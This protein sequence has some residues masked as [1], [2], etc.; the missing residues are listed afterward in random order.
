VIYTAL[1][2]A[3][4]VRWASAVRA[5]AP[6]LGVLFPGL[7]VGVVTRSS[8]ARAVNAAEVSDASS[9]SDIDD[10]DF[11][12]D[13]GHQ[14]FF[15]AVGL[16]FEFEECN[17]MSITD[18]VRRPGEA[19]DVDN[20]EGLAGCMRDSYNQLTLAANRML[21]I[22]SG[23]GERRRGLLAQAHEQLPAIMALDSCS[24]VGAEPAPKRS[25]SGVVPKARQGRLTRCL[26]VVRKVREVVMRAAEAI[27]D[28]RDQAFTRDMS[29]IVQ[30]A[31]V[32][33]GLVPKIAS[34]LRAVKS[35]MP[36][37]LV[38]QLCG[39]SGELW[40]FCV[41]LVERPT[42]SDRL[43]LYGANQSSG[44][45]KERC[46]KHNRTGEECAALEHA[47][48]TAC[49]SPWYET[50]DEGLKW[51]W[52]DIC[53]GWW[54][55]VDTRK[56]IEVL[57]IGKCSV[58]HMEVD[59]RVLANEPKVMFPQQ[60]DLVKCM[61]SSLKAFSIA[62]DALVFIAGG[63]LRHTPVNVVVGA[64]RAHTWLEPAALSEL[65]C[66]EVEQTI[67][68]AVNASSGW[69]LPVPAQ[70]L[71]RCL[72]LLERV[73]RVAIPSEPPTNKVDVARRLTTVAT[74]IPSAR[75]RLLDRGPIVDVSLL[76][77]LCS[78][79]MVDACLAILER[80][81]AKRLPALQYDALRLAMDRFGK[82]C[83]SPKAESVSQCFRLVDAV[84][85]L[86][87][88]SFFGSHYA[89]A[90]GAWMLQISFELTVDVS[91]IFARGQPDPPFSPPLAKRRRRAIVG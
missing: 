54:G 65:P 63:M 7:E 91:S 44:Y 90:C 45:Y 84:T 46:L 60:H 6:D 27:G 8:A 79:S 68:E 11:D 82:R 2:A 32:V 39:M 14:R 1:L 31:V 43:V 80:D 67:V 74:M 47:V 75:T 33:S 34:R 52:V 20:D 42:S 69:K 9:S 19:Q 50:S 72:P 58:E 18:S 24:D 89:E 70:Q 5:I 81:S 76:R 62:T 38:E 26:P 3:I 85:S 12:A 35:V 51:W 15:D 88:D 22:V 61:R 30:A 40:S 25:S 49:S 87:R 23:P 16:E 64:K 37:D 17:E 48:E 71:R 36:S 78:S 83:L 29:V 73:W 13:G 55:Q 53:T 56:S 77:G 4:A 86:C 41:M 59:L 57:D 28:V 66:K 10:D 21:D